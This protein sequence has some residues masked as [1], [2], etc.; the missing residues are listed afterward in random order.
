MHIPTILFVGLLATTPLFSGADP[1]IETP[2]PT[3][4]FVGCRPASQAASS[5]MDS[6][7]AFG[8]RGFV[9]KDGRLWVWP[10][11]GSG[12]RFWEQEASRGTPDLAPTLNGGFLRAPLYRAGSFWRRK[13][14]TILKWDSPSRL[15]LLALEAG[16]RFQSFEVT[17]DGDILLLGTEK[18]FLERFSYQGKDPLWTAPYPDLGVG[19]KVARAKT[20]LWE[21]LCTAA[22]QEA[23]LVYAPALGRL[24]AYDAMRGDLGEVKVPWRPLDL[25]RE[26]ARAASQ[27]LVVLAGFP[28]P[29]CLQFLPG[30]GTQPFVAYRVKEV[31]GEVRW[32]PLRPGQAPDLKIE[33]K[34]GPLCVGE[35][36]LASSTLRDPVVL[37][38]LDLPVWRNPKGSFEPLAGLMKSAPPRA[39]ADAKPREGPGPKP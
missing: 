29:G 21:A 39:S 27:G 17:F 37:G 4:V 36:D 38:E 2:E 28:G 33:T 32:T 19:E 23:L 7:Q 9:L 13:D 5:P 16:G 6:G 11:E 8:G 3:V 31:I 12:G 26:L 35:L 14:Q 34:Q 22:F 10:A 30:P 15:W 25:K 20:F 18:H 1:S 24:Y